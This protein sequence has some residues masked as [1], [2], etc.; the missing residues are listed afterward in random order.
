MQEY[1]LRYQTL[2][3]DAHAA[4]AY[5]A[6]RIL[7]EAIKR[8]GTTDNVQLRDALA[9][10]KDFDGVTG[11]ISI[12]A[13]RNAVK[14]AVVLKLQDVRSIFEERIQ[15]IPLASTGRSASSPPQPSEVPSAPRK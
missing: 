4:L 3:P 2:M 7:F 13:Q 10:T 5:D 8:A 15:P 11:L 12:D 6:A 14:P 1:K 9:Q